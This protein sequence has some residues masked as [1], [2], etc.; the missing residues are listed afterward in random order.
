VGKRDACRRGSVSTGASP[1]AS[2][3]VLGRAV[4]ALSGLGYEVR[5]AGYVSEPTAHNQSHNRARSAY[6]LA[7]NHR[8]LSALRFGSGRIRGILQRSSL[9]PGLREPE[10]MRISIARCLTSLAALALSTKAHALDRLVPAQ[11]PTIQAAVNACSSG[12]RILLESGIYREGIVISGKTVVLE[13]ALP[14]S[15]NR[16]VLDGENVRR[17]IML[18]SAGLTARN[19]RFI[20]GNAAVTPDRN[21]GAINCLNSQL[22]AE[23]CDFMNCSASYTPEVQGGGGAVH[24]LSGSVSLRRC[25]LSGNRAFR[26]SSVF[27]CGSI[28]DCVFE[29]PQ[30]GA[31]AIFSSGGSTTIDGCDLADSVIYM[32]NAI[33]RLKDT[34][35]CGSTF[36]ALEAGATLTDLGGN[37]TLASCDCNS[38]GQGDFGQIFTGSLDDDNANGIPDVCETSVTGVIPPSVPSQGGATVTIKGANFPD[39]PNVLIGG[40]AATDVVRLSATRITATS[41]ALLPGMASISVNGF[42]L[43]EAL[44]IRPECGSDL[45]QNGV[46]D[47][48]DISIILLDF[49]PCASNLPS[50]LLSDPSAGLRTDMAQLRAHDIRPLPP[51]FRSTRKRAAAE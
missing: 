17:I 36:V 5:R 12:D 42:T 33:V 39:H 22:V 7:H 13:A 43:P 4:R 32:V 37:V 35:S 45:D 38:D 16:P 8:E 46:V 1:K 6:P 40:V 29:A 49:G 41:P 24:C 48:A 19:I 3:L 44:Y 34:N 18:Q 47:T 26:G 23:D 30:S 15:A 25:H 2:A 28:Q 51:K 11:Y 10:R 20:N 27:N 9:I 31:G 50:P 21:G 14:G